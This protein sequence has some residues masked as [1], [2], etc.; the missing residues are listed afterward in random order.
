MFSSNPG[1]NI[2]YYL[3][4]INIETSSTSVKLGKTLEYLIHSKYTHTKLRGL[5]REPEEPFRHM[6][7]SAPL[8]A[9]FGL[10]VCSHNG[11]T[12]SYTTLSMI[13]HKM[14]AKGADLAP[15]GSLTFYSTKPCY[16]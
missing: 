11:F 4:I 2:Q 12:W 10:Y 9:P 15:S 7:P 8:K 14:A 16:F 1:V 3:K 5:L 13:I 6:A